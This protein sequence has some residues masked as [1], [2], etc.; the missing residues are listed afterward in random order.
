MLAGLSKLADA[1]PADVRIALRE[2]T[3]EPAFAPKVGATR[4]FFVGPFDAY[5]EDDAR[6]GGEPSLVLVAP[7]ATVRL[8]PSESLVEAVATREMVE[9]DAYA[10]ELALF[11]ALS[12]ALRTHG[13]FH[14]HAGAVAMPDDR[15][16]LV[17]GASG[18]GKTTTTLA[19]AAAGARPLGDDTL[20]LWRATTGPR[21]ASFR[22]SFH[23]GQHTQELFPALRPFVGAPLA[24]GAV[25]CALDAT[26][27]FEGRMADFA[28]APSVILCPVVR[29]AEATRVEPVHPMH[30]TAAIIESSALITIPGVAKTAEQW[31]LM[32][33]LVRDARVYSVSL[34]VGAL[35]LRGAGVV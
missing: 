35:D 9:T 19:L 20:F 29:P 2:G 7:G 23:V 14:L 5:A 16:V 22:R 18:A 10:I 30:A 28:A 25:K 17:L 11:V 3:P 4:A 1:G 8:S 31:R 34:G 15:S 12:I 27:A 26:R 13:R 6:A 32:G 33:D 24:H 21:L